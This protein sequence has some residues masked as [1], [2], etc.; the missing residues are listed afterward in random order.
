MT[1][2]I[3]EGPAVEPVTVE[4]LK[5]HLNVTLDGDDALIADK[6]RAAR[7]HIE[8]FAGI[9]MIEQTLKL[10]LDRFPAG[11]FA[12][13]RPPLLEVVAI[14]YVDPLLATQALPAE[15]FVVRGVGATGYLAPVAGW[16]RTDLLP[17]AVEVTFKAGYGQAAEDVPEPLREAV[18]QLAAHLYENREATI[19]GTS[20]ANVLPYG[21]EELIAD[22]RQWSFG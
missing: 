18:R 15:A 14:G 8:R 3:I 21:V 4:D 11:F 20:S 2:I 7:T 12:L 9:A 17:G 16:P 19:V 13:P 5:A 6:I 10:V 1:V 22:Y